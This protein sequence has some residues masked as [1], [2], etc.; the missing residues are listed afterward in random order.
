MTEQTEKIPER[1]PEV[2]E[3]DDWREALTFLILRTRI[4]FQ[5]GNEA[6]PTLPQTVEIFT[7]AHER[8]WEYDGM[9]TTAFFMRHEGLTSEDV[10]AAVYGMAE[11]GQL[12]EEDF[13][14][15]F[16]SA[17]SSEGSTGA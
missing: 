5:K 17:L 12:T 2:V 10:A 15:I 9:Q 7:R 1:L 14:E 13:E 8:G 4:E 3:T 6:D 16:A 11:S